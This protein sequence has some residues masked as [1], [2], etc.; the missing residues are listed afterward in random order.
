MPTLWDTLLLS[1]VE[2]VNLLLSRIDATVKSPLYAV[3]PIPDVFVEDLTFL[4]KILS[5]TLRWCGFSAI[6]VTVPLVWL[7]VL[8][9]LGFLW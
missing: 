1:I 3:K 9:N 2:Y 5:P 8:I 6:T 4:I 7:H